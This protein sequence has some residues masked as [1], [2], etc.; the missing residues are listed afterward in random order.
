[1]FSGTP[2]IA[3]QYTVTLKAVSTAG[4]T[5]ETLLLN[6]LG[7]AGLR[8]FMLPG[9]LVQGSVGE[10]HTVEFSDALDPNSWQTA[11]TVVVTNEAQFYVD[12][13]ATNSNRRFLPHPVKLT[14]C[15]ARPR[16]KNL[17]PAPLM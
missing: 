3:G 8:V 15:S 6:V 5:N 14:G 17:H 12:F 10:I 4:E 11:G 9:I 13:S 1:L 7:S 2:T 16:R